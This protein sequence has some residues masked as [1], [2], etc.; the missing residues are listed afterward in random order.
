MLQMIISGIIIAISIVLALIYFIR[1]FYQIGKDN[2]ACA[3]CKYKK[4]C[5]QYKEIKKLK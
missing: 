2:S 3:C 5:V 4:E 1:M